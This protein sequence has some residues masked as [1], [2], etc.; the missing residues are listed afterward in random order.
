MSIWTLDITDDRGTRSIIG[1]AENPAASRAA[2]AAAIGHLSQSGGYRHQRYHASIDGHLLAI[3]GTTADHAG[4]TE[5][6]ALLGQPAACPPD[7]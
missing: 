3:I 2:A 6:L 4:L 1:T 5:L 7:L